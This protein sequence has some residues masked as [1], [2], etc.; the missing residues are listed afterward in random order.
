MKK[1]LLSV[2]LLS[3]FTAAVARSETISPDRPGFANGTGIVPAGAIQL[4]SGYLYSRVEEVKE[5]TLGQ[6]LSERLKHLAAEI[7]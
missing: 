1:F 2:F 3:V 6:S 5:H 4:E 7:A